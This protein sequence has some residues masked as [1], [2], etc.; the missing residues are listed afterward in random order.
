MVFIHA[1]VGHVPFEISQFLNYL[2]TTGEYANYLEAVLGKRKR[3]FSLVVPAKYK[4]KT[5]DRRFANILREKLEEKKKIHNI[6][7]R[8]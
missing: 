5:K 2:L 8:L 7:I 6:D 3:E 4:A 1:L